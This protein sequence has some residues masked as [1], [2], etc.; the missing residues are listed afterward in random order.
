MPMFAE[1]VELAQASWVLPGFRIVLDDMIDGI[2]EGHQ[3]GGI[4]GY[5][6]G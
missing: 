4:T 1:A 3:P 5:D 6:L 2:V